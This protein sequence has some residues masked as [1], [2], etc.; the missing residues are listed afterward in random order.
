[1]S[2]SPHHP[3]SAEIDA[4]ASDWI[5]RHES[6]LTVAER[7]EFDRWQAADSRHR[8]AVDRLSQT[9]A[10]LD[11]PRQAGRATE[12]VQALS[13]RAKRRRR[14][15][16]SAVVALAGMF[17]AGVLWQ[18]ADFRRPVE[19]A[20][21]AT[22]VVMPEVRVLPDGGRVE[23]KPGAEISIDYGG[24][25]RRVVLHR[26]E[27]LFHVMENKERPF[28]V[29]AGNVD[30]RA[31]GTVF[32]VTTG[33]RH[34][35]VV[36]THGRVAVEPTGSAQHEPVHRTESPLIEPASTLVDAGMRV[37]VQLERPATGSDVVAISPIEIADR[38]AWCGPRVEFNGT[39]LA[40]AVAL[41][42]RHSKLRLVV[43]D[44]MLAKLPV[45]G[46]FRADNTETL[47]RLLEVGFGVQAE[48][49]G[50]TI[51]LR[52]AR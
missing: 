6:P 27:A 51:T 23:L 18:T 33:S 28:V 26:G 45:N 42:N 41:M 22:V 16:V 43:D 15:T 9:W 39:A 8:A 38:L 35:D 52:K 32:L 20:R 21:I 12:M 29:T 34:V 30:V 46:L 13:L 3:S 50:D 25:L 49:T 37:T 48:R 40:D 5:L 19:P 44:P 1:M 17:G 4:V 31:V 10:L 2:R 7:A 36:V 11:Q 14:K 47:V 24:K